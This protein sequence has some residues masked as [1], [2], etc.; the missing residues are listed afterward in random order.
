MPGVATPLSPPDDSESGPQPQ[1]RRGT[2]E[3]INTRVAAA[4][5]PSLGSAGSGSAVFNFEGE[6]L[7]AVVKAILGDMLGQNYVIAPNVQ[8]TVT[9]GTPKPVS[10]A[11]ALN[12]LEMV[13]GWNNARMVYSGGR[14]N[15]MPADS[16]LDGSVSPRT[17]TATNARGYEVR[18]VPLRYISATEMKKVLEPYAR[19]NAIVGLDSTR[20]LITLAGTR[21]ELENYLRTVQ[22]FDVDW[23]AGMSVGVFPLQS[24]RASKVVEDLEKVFGNSSG[25]PSAGM[26]RF[27]PLEG[28][29]AVLVIT[30]QESYLDQIQQWLDQIDSAGGGARLF[31]YELK[32]IRARE[33]AERLSEVFSVGQSN[34]GGSSA[35]LA[36]GA[37][38]TQINSSGMDSQSNASN[39]SS[40]SDSSTTASMGSSAGSSSGGLGEGSMQLGRQQSGNA[41]VTLEVD[42]GRV[43]VSA[44]EETNSLLVRAT[45]Q[46]WRSIRD[47]IEQLDVM[48]TQ[49]HIEAQVVEVELTGDLSYGV[50]WF[51]DNAVSD[52][53]TTGA[54]ISQ[55][56]NSW[57]SLAGSVTGGNGLSW[58]FLGKNAAAIIT[59]LDKVSNVNI[60]QTPSIF[61]R[62]NAEATLNV[63]NR[64]PISSVSVNTSGSSDT[65]YS[66]VQ[67][68]DTGIILK[69]R[70]RVTRDGMVFL[71]IVQ[72][73]STPV[74]DRD[75]DKNGNVQINTRRMRTEAAVQEG[76]TVMLAGL[77]QDTASRG[78]SGV[79]GLS[80]IPVIGALFGKRTSNNKRS[81]MIILLTPTL[82]R[83]PMEAENLTDE[84]GRRFRALSPI[85]RERD[86]RARQ[87]SR[88]GTAPQSGQGL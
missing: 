26:F 45:P 29:N 14:Y 62:N 81:E 4:P 80:R 56:R 41:S 30:S 2:G 65:T 52:S 44:V 63:G 35:S 72:E 40:L 70:P 77:I 82:V 71:D 34:A 57:G 50:S 83:N 6:S 64:I 21:T 25:T 10:P 3:V 38:S 17:G 9:L 87:Q 47:V 32:Y 54:G 49:V 22:I 8:G 59:A 69:V 85:Y 58:T 53:G 51:F 48:P 61:V 27:M 75:P 31:S 7:Q 11:E 28:A 55:T 67:Y 15:I 19:P 84:Y 88:N 23:L 1:I 12:L 60:L 43:G 33:L 24:G 39:L 18:V 74:E 76:S 16:A 13:L 42:G 73:V 78:S 36:P 86:E 5:G 46:A 68:I 79:P 37:L 20:N 66:T